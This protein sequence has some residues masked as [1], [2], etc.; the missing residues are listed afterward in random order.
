MCE[1]VKPGSQGL[2]SRAGTPRPAETGKAEDQ[3]VGCDGSEDDTTA[4]HLDR[5]RRETIKIE[6]APVLGT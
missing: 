6:I 1:G 3:T 2:E 4:G 5:D